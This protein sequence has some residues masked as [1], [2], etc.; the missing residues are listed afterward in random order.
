MLGHRHSSLWHMILAPTVWA[1]H[2][3]VVY[4]WTAVQCARAGGPDAART[5]ILIATAVALMAIV[6]LGWKAW[7]Q[8]ALES[9]TR[10]RFERKTSHFGSMACRFGFRV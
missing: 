4:G 9:I 7:R 3:C 6:V 10:P 2:F 8:W 5:G 1:V